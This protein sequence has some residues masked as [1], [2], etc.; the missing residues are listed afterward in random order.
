[1]CEQCFQAA[2]NDPEG[3]KRAVQDFIEIE[4]RKPVNRLKR[5]YRRLL[6]L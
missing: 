6:G 1:M 4:R 5:A 3:F 2:K